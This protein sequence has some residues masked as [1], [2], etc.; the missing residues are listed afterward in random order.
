MSA[1][2]HVLASYEVEI[3]FASRKYLKQVSKILENAPTITG[4]EGNASVSLVKLPGYRLSFYDHGRRHR[5]QTHVVVVVQGDLRD[6]ER[7][8]TQYELAAFEA[9]LSCHF[10]ICQRAVS[11]T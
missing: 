10:D 5:Y 3:G 11:L 8:R 7:E 1:W 2:T 9:F 4:S 6:R